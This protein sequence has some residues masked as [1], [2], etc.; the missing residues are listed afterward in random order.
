MFESQDHQQGMRFA[1]VVVQKF[2]PLLPLL[3]RFPK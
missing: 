3:P 2:A 1:G